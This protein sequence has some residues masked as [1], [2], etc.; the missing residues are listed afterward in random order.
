MGEHAP[1]S[2]ELDESLGGLRKALMVAGQTTPPNNPA[3]GTFNDPA[4][5]P[6]DVFFWF[7]VFAMVFSS[8]HVRV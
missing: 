8:R 4:T 1:A 7:R 3:K 2:R 5:L 6:P